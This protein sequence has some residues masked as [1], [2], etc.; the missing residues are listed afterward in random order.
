MDTQE[1]TVLHV[2]AR[3]LAIGGKHGSK[4]LYFTALWDDKLAYAMGLV[5]LFPGHGKLEEALGR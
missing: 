5:L 1:G 4:F 3:S 2:H